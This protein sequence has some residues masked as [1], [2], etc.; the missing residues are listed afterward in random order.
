MTEGPNIDAK[1]VEGFGEEWHAFTQEELDPAEHRRA[2]E[3]YF[4]IF[5]FDELPADA[6]GF[7]LGP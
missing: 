3:E 5:P 6:E 7:D 1:T 4:S 2:F